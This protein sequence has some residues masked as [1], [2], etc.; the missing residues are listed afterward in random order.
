MVI[1]AL[2]STIT[3]SDF[4]LDRHLGS[5]AKE[6]YLLIAFTRPTSISELSRNSGMSRGTI[7]QACEILLKSGWLV[8]TASGA[9]GA[10]YAATIPRSVQKVLARQI[11]ADRWAAAYA[12]E[13]LMRLWLD[14][15]VDSRE[16]LDNA[17]PRFL[18]NPST[19]RPLE[20]DR[21]YHV[22]VGF[23]FQG[24]QHFAKTE[25]YPDDERL[26]HRQ[27]LDLVKAGQCARH[28]IQL[29]EVVETDLSLQGMVAKVPPPLTLRY[30]EANSP[31]MQALS[32]LSENY[33][34]NSRRL[35]GGS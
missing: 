10:V 16:F 21:L 15:L 32:N 5:T 9:K 25:L 1:P 27:T 33:A 30:Y 26:A 4:A 24:W 8:Q 12:G 6:V 29:V 31:I 20:V 14:W 17:R 19:G 2:G 34:S 13:H 28:G 22:G 18:V 23:E 7:R 35:R 11:E 3:Y